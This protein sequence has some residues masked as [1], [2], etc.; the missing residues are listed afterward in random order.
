M[1]G[2]SI[3]HA[4]EV[5]SEYEVKLTSCFGWCGNHHLPG[6]EDEVG[7]AL[8]PRVTFTAQ[9]NVTLTTTGDGNCMFTTASIRLE[10]KEALGDV[11]PVL[12]A[13]QLFFF[14]D[15]YV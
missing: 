6:K 10:G 15:Y 11:I 7:T 1:W 5:V 9:N 3:E 12:V 13:R 4:K 2:G 8:I 14:P